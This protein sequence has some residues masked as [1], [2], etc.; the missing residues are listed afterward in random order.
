MK[1][2]NKKENLVKA[3]A[4]TDT[5]TVEKPQIRNAII[6]GISLRMENG[7]V[8][9]AYITLAMD[10]G[11]Q[12]FGGYILHL[13][14][15]SPNHAIA[16]KNNFAGVFIE[17]V[18]AIAGV[19]AWEQLPGRPVRIK[20]DH[21]KIYSIGH[22]FNDQWFDPDQEFAVMRKDAG[23]P[24]KSAAAPPLGPKPKDKK[25]QEKSVEQ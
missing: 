9:T 2:Q 7:F 20:N 14:A 4:A 8:L 25:V 5:K 3:P 13:N 23:V 12:N 11:N 22:I 24:E 10:L 18:L 16:K 6:Q 21:D 1:K 19:Q 17:R 15:E